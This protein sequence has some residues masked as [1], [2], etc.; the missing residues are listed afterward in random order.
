MSNKK[1]DDE[2]ENAIALEEGDEKENTIA[3]EELPILNSKVIPFG[4]LVTVPAINIR[5]GPSMTNEVLKVLVNH[6]KVI[7]IDHIDGLWGK[8]EGFDNGWINLNHT[9][10]V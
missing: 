7:M 1:K 8:I 5:T 9:K 4:V 2:K 3:P 6:K 10:E